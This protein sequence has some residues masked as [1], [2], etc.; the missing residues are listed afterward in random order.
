MVVSGWEWLG[1]YNSWIYLAVSKRLLVL[2]RDVR[3]KKLLLATV[4]VIAL[5]VGAQANTKTRRARPTRARCPIMHIFD[6]TRILRR[7][8]RHQAGHGES[9]FVSVGISGSAP[10]ATSFAD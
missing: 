6:L 5:T 1:L 7:G 8:G 2:H 3:M 4:F 10:G 9:V